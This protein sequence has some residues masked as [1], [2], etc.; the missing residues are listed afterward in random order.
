MPRGRFNCAEAAWPPSPL[1]PGLPVPA[2]VVMIPE[3]VTLRIRLFPES[4]MYKSPDG[5]NAAAPGVCNWA[6]VAGRESPLNPPAPLPATVRIALP[7][8][9]LRTRLPKYSVI[10]TAPVGSANKP[11]GAVS[12]VAVGERPSRGDAGAPVPATVDITP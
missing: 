9:S 3:A 8:I 2:K 4:A 5:L 1:Y 6:L 11:T 10:Q 7:G 12:G